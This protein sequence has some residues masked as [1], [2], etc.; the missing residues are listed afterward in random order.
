VQQIVRDGGPSRPQSGIC[1][2]Y[3][4]SGRIPARTLAGAPEFIEFCDRDASSMIAVRPLRD[5]MDQGSAAVESC[6]ILSALLLLIVGSIE[7]GRAMWA[8]NTMLLAVQAAGR[9]AMISNDAP[10]ISCDAQRQ[11][12]S[13]PT[14]SNT[15]LANCAAALAHQILSSYQAANIDVSVRE[16]QTSTPALITICAS[17]SYG[18]AAPG[19]L[20]FG[21][22]NLKSQVTVPRVAHR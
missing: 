8:E 21:P 16:D 5:R 4:V 18:F 15:P 1:S 10:P 7:F 22:L 3:R 11:A 2:D 12:P 6:I 20:P 17:H 19:L 13:C 9:F 14:L